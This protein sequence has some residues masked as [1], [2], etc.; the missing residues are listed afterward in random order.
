MCPNVCKHYLIIYSCLKFI[1]KKVERIKIEK[2]KKK[3]KNCENSKLVY[4][5]YLG[6]F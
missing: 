1:F 3:L 2:L 4:P 6:D 5:R